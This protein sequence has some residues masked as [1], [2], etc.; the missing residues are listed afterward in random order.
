MLARPVVMK[1]RADGVWS[2]TREWRVVFTKE[3]E[4]RSERSRVAGMLADNTV[5]R[6]ECKSMER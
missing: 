2:R 3:H 5:W 1:S 4:G 6:W